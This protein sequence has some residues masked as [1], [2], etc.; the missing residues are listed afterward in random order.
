MI[1]S[2]PTADEIFEAEKA[3][4]TRQKHRERGFGG[5]KL[6]DQGAQVLSNGVTMR[7]PVVDR[8]YPDDGVW[9]KPRNIP[10]GKFLLEIDNKEIAFDAEEFRKWLRWV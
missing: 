7:W 3:K 5:M 10:E 9:V 1:K 2:V 6:R 4:E 8:D